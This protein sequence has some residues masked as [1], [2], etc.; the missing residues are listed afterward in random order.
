MAGTGMRPPLRSILGCRALEVDLANHPALDF[1]GS[2]LMLDEPIAVFRIVQ[3]SFSA[4]CSQG[5][6]E[7]A[8]PVPLLCRPVPSMFRFALWL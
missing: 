4:C 2:G 8:A 3:G 7:R 1:S 6:S 5:L